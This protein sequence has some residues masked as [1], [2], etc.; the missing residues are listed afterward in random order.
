[1]KHTQQVTNQ[2]VNTIF[3][4]S[5]FIILRVRDSLRYY[6]AFWCETFSYLIN[7]PGAKLA[8]QSLSPMILSSAILSAYR[9]YFQGK[10]NMIPTAI[11]QILEAT[12]KI[13][14]G[15]TLAFLLLNCGFSPKYLAAV[16]LL[17]SPSV[18][19]LH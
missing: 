2:L 10:S 17:G 5:R 14:I 7:S 12:I 19:L 15:T 4:L 3:R 11:T 6:H 16:R 1:M 13:V 18:Q 9:G 8:I